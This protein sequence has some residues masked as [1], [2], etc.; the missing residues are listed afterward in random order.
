MVDGHPPEGSKI[1]NASRHMITCHLN[2]YLLDPNDCLTNFPKQGSIY[3][4]CPFTMDLSW[5]SILDDLFT[6]DFG[7]GVHFGCVFYDGFWGGCPFWMCPFWMCLAEVVPGSGK[8]ILFPSRPVRCSNDRFYGL[9]LAPVRGLSSYFGG[10]W[11]IA[12]PAA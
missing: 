7:V 3:R 8:S 12:V 5:V 2:S 10:E 4:G 9:I 6:M 11:I 1:E